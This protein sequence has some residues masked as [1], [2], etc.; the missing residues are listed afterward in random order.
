[1]A[2]HFSLRIDISSLQSIAEVHFTF[3]LV[4]GEFVIFN[5]MSISHPTQGQMQ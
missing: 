4:E 5:I 2:V 1:M 3:K